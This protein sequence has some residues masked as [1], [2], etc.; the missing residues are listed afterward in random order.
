MDQELLAEAR[1]LDPGTNDAALL[2]AAL[3]ALVARHRRDEID[4]SYAAY[5]EHPLGEAD[6]WGD[7]ASFRSAAAA[8]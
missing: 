3:A 2:D 7:L 1:N 4:A 8:S 6:E 5:D